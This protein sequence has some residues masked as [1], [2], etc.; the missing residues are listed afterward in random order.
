MQ[1]KEYPH[2]RYASIELEAGE[3]IPAGN[4]EYIRL[5]V[6][7]SFQRNREMT[8]AGF[9]LI[10]RTVEVKVPIAGGKVDFSR[11]CR[12]PVVRS[13]ENIERVRRI[14]KESFREDHRFL[15]TFSAEGGRL[16]EALI[17]AWVDETD[18]TFQCRCKDDVAGFADVVCSEQYGG[19]PFIRLA[20][21][22]P[23]YRIAGA[24][25]SLYAAV[26]AHFRDAGAR[27]VYGRISTRNM[28]VMNL[29]S[30]FGAQFAKPYDI[31]IKR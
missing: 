28:A 24:A 20:A 2:L 19:M 7:E 10:D 31:Y 3:E 5:S 16:A 27:A 22:A 25:M 13:G 1:Q 12:L 8:E 17:D 29:Y 21:V 26:F 15:V 14:A 30:S 6:P 4:F 11:F 18:V 23:A 9:A